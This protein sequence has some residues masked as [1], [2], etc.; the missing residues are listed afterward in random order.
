MANADKK[1]GDIKMVLLELLS[2]L[3][4][5]QYIKEITF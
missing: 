2:S 3:A 4:D 5:L 1:N